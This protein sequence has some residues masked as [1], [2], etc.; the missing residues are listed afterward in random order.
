MQIDP[1]IVEKQAIYK[2]LIGCVVPRPIAWVSSIDATGIANVAPFSFFMAVCN[3]P[4]TLAFSSGRRE[5]SK[6]DTIRN[7]EY[8]HDFVVNIVDDALAEQMNLTSGEYPPDVDEFAITG[9]TAAAGVKVKAPRVVE[10]PISMEC[11]VTQILP[12]GHGPHSLVLGEI[13]HFH[14]RD[15]LYNPSTG[16]IDM[17]A[18]HPVG[19]LAGNL[20]THVHDIFEMKRPV[21]NYAG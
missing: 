1:E 3:D 20:Y 21:E 7:I 15:D 17:H 16:R 12:V 14:I 18:L 6:K 8:S 13:V 4:P 11:R 2:L 10:A 9:L 19:R 5:G